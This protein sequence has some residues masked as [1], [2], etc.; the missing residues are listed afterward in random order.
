MG[1]AFVIPAANLSDP[2]VIAMLLLILYASLALLIPLAV[3]FRRQSEARPTRPWVL[4]ACSR[5]RHPPR[6]RSTGRQARSLPAAASG[7][8]RGEG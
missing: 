2:H 7:V 5:G 4:R 1:A 8:H 6:Q 3:V